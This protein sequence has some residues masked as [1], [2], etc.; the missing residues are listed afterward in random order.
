MKN[1][2]YKYFTGKIVG[3]YFLL[4]TQPLSQ[5]IF[6]FYCSDKML[7]WLW[8]PRLYGKSLFTKIFQSKVAC[9][10]CSLHILVV[11]FPPKD[12]L[13]FGLEFFLLFCDKVW[14]MHAC[15]LLHVNYLHW[16]IKDPSY[17]RSFVI[18]Q[19]S[20]F[21]MVRCSSIE[22]FVYSI[23]MSHASCIF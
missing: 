11:S 7:L 8:F 21:F 6:P 17:P 18:I 20:F 13:Q 10:C 12:G 23:H 2:F 3:Y 16:Y 4:R 9:I 5:I 1:M 14:L 19:V 15:Y 22:R